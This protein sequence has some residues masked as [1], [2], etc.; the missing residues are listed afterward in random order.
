VR[1][2]SIVWLIYGH[3]IEVALFN[4]P[5]QNYDGPIRSSQTPSVALMY[6]G[7]YA[8]DTFFWMTG[9]L[10]GY[11]MLKEL[12]GKQGRM[13]WGL[14]YL[15][16]YIRI[17]PANLFAVFFNWLLTEKMLN[18]PLCFFYDL[19]YADCNEYWWTT[20]LFLMNFV[21]DFKGNTCFGIGWYLANDM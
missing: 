6:G 3:V 9:I 18:G 5:L 16:R 7:Y 10:T 8:V 12:A 13:Q 19:L 1:V 14:V 2:L 21:P 17:L 11:L 20:P 15:H 4:R